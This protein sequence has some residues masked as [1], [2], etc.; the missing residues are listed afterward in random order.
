[1]TET[2]GAIDADKLNANLQKLEELNRRFLNVLAKRK[3][4]NPA[5]FGPGQEFYSDAFTA[6]MRD[7][8][9][10]PARLFEQQVSY[11]GESL[12]NWMR[13]QESPVNQT[14]GAENEAAKQDSRFQS[15]HWD[16]SPFFKLV[17][18]QYLTNSS[19]VRRAVE[20]MGGIDERQRRRLEFFS[21]QIVEMMSPA[22]FLATNPEA[23]ER[24]VATE[25]ESLVRG[26]ENL[27]RDLERND[28][29]LLVTLADTEAFSV[30]G[31][32]A[33]SEGEIVFRNELFELIQF[34]P[35]TER[36]HRIPLL[37]VPPW[38]NKYYILDL[39]P[40]NSFIRW[41]VEQGFTVFVVSWVN[42][43]EAHREVGMDSYASDG[44]LAAVRQVKT[45]TG[46]ERIN[47]V[48]YC[49]GGT[50]LAL[51]LAYMSKTGDKS[52]RSATFFA[53]LTDFSELGELAVFI[54]NDFLEAIENEVADKGYLPS[55]YMSRTFSFM[56]ASDLVYGPAVRSYLMGEAPPAFDLLYW[57]GDSTNM[58]ARMTVEYLRRL[59]Q[60][61]QFGGEGFEIFG[62]T[63]TLGDVRHPVMAVACETDHIANWPGSY[64]GIAAMGS[65]DKSF[66]LSQ[67]GHIAGIINPPSRDRYG[68]YT[69]ASVP[70]SASEWRENARLNEGS[71]WRSWGEW[72]SRRSGAMIDAR[73]PEGNGT[74][75]LGPAPGEYVLAPGQ[76]RK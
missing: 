65:R 14:D 40:E 46:E 4:S 73:R 60:Q 53:T 50:L 51:V 76:G 18:E 32:L 56:R 61:N 7:S 9:A 36:A 16:A 31:N 48:G 70:A 19:A 71:W 13:L 58:P 69:C 5:M 27:V 57:N 34:S 22:N 42:P 64:R 6:V 2:A 20:E 39:K 41:T 8:I 44:C 59:C 1:M 74:A 28:G 33:T 11:W 66:V 38:I 62:E 17:K 29:E 43:T 12:Q 67:S 49:I 21:R 75:G 23:L 24:A 63:V 35:L 68:H 55:I 45:I 37:I 52:I 10:N 15:G 47:A 30:G 25:G 54:E 26:L 3:P 72:L